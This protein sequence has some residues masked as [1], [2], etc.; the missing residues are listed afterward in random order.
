MK[1]ATSFTLVGA[2]SIVMW[3]AI[4]PLLR[5]SSE[6]AGMFST[7]LVVQGVAGALGLEATLK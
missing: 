3:G 2:I 1:S 5:L 4:L 6:R 7:L